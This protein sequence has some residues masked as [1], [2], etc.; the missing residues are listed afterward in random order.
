VLTA[1]ADTVLLLLGGKQGSPD[2][3]VTAEEFRTLIDVSEREGVLEETERKMIDNIFDFSN[4]TVQEIM[5]PRTDMFCL[6]LDDTRETIL[7]KCRKE[8]YARL[9]VYQD[10]I[11]RICG[12]VYV[13]NLL[14]Y[15]QGDCHDFHLRK[16]LRDAYFVPETKKVQD[17]LRE[18]QEKHI[19]IAIVVDEYGG[20]AGLVCLEDILEE[21]VGEISD[22]FDLEEMPMYHPVVEGGKEYTVSAM[23]H[24]YDF[25]QKFGAYFSPDYYWTVGGLLL[26]LLG[27][28]P[29]KGDT[30]TV[31][32]LTMTVN[33][34]RYNRIMEVTVKMND[35]Q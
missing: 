27:K 23:M 18:F 20:T 9:P 28:V 7:E 21:I 3:M 24:I 11:D 10:T 14:P 16:V 8:L 5:I 22:E 12:V 33:K 13:K 29:Q 17:L 1:I 15:I 34:L 31:G 26:E 6:S 19:H 2:Q 32:N 35:K 30:V 25:N 4:L